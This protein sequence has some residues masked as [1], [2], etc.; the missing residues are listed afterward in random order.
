MTKRDEL[1][2]K[3]ESEL[4]TG[5]VSPFGFGERRYET[6][7]DSGVLADFILQR[8]REQI[9]RV[10]EPLRSYGFIETRKECMD[11][12][13]AIADEIIKG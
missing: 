11:K 12:S 13:L 2:K 8:E 5:I 10:V 6:Q 3:I 1:I 9:A 4:P 7:V